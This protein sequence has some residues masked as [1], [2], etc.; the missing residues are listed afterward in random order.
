[1]H[2]LGVLALLPGDRAEELDDV[3]G[4]VVLHCGAVADG[5]DISQGCANYA[6]VGVGFNCVLV[7]LSVQFGAESI[8][9][10][11]AG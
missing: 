11:S 9:D 4:N 6:Q 2:L 1:M 3:A 8:T 5:V 10:L 7:V